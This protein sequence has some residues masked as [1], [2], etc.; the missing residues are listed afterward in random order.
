PI[1]MIRE[2]ETQGNY[3]KRLAMLEEFK[4]MPAHDIWNK[5]CLD[6]KVPSGAGWIKEIEDYEREILSK[7]T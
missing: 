6:N 4:H 2:L 3:T 7:R 5:F 1:E